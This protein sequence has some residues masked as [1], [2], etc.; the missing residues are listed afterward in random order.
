M[1]KVKG[2]DCGGNERPVD[3]E[4]GGVID[5]DARKN[6]KYDLHINSYS[7]RYVPTLAAAFGPWIDEQR[8]NRSAD[9]DVTHF[10]KYAK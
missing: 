10:Y 1:K 9:I 7:R 5:E 3:H 8:I 2:T 4:E 6:R